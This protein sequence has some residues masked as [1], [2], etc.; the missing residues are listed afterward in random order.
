MFLV[1]KMAEVE[2]FEIL[3]NILANAVI[4]IYY[5]VHVILKN[6]NVRNHTL[7]ITCVLA[8]HNHIFYYDELVSF[9]TK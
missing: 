4:L 7:Q 9:K 8:Y 5:K 6:S 1:V 3:L 2:M